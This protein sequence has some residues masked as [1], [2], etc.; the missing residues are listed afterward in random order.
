MDDGDSARRVGLSPRMSA[1]QRIRRGEM[2]AFGAETYPDGD[3]VYVEVLELT[4]R[5]RA[6]RPRRRSSLGDTV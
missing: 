3:I 5:P 4:L 2:F 6:R 1:V